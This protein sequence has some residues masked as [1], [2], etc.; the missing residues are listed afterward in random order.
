MFYARH[1]ISST[2]TTGMWALSQTTD[3]E[4]FDTECSKLERWYNDFNP[5]FD[6][7]RD[8]K[9]KTAFRFFKRCFANTKGIIEPQDPRVVIYLCQQAIR[10]MYYDTLGRNLSQTLLKYITGLCQVLFGPQH[11]LYI[12]LLQLSRMNAF[13][14]AQ[15][16][17][18]FMDCYFD[19]L[20]PFVANSN[21]AFGHITEMRGLTVSLMEGTGMIGI[22]EAK[23]VLD[24]LVAKAED[25]GLPT[26]HLKVETAA[27]LSRNRFFPEALSLLAEVRSSGE[28]ET[29]P[30]EYHYAGIVLMITYKK[31]KNLAESIK[32]GYE[33]AEFLSKPPNTYPGYPD[34][35]SMSLRQYLESRPSSLLLVLGKLEVDLRETGRIEEADKIKN[36]LNSGVV[37]TI[38]SEEPGEDPEAVVKAM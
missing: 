31:M 17:R 32:I 8:N 10:C 21:N 38:G 3:P 5:A 12:I 19:H 9:V 30:Y 36:R 13:E 15:T 27:I 34:D 1:F 29:N 4:L 11:P 6:M 18:P 22:Y 24:N 28:A 2:F 14:F 35:L 25:N 16:I 7:L 20:E 26:L 33:M 37:E 23:P